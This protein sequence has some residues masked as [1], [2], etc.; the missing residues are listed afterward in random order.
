VNETG[1]AWNAYLADLDRMGSKELAGI[2][3]KYIK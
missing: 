2:I 3:Q 1:D